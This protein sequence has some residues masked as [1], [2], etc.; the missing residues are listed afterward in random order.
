MSPRRRRTVAEGFGQRR[1]GSRWQIEHLG[2]RRCAVVRDDGHRNERQ[3][4]VPRR[5]EVYWRHDQPR[6]HQQ[7][8]HRGP[9]GVARSDPDRVGRPPGPPLPYH[10]RASVGRY[11]GTRVALRELSTTP[12]PSR[13]MRRS[14]VRVGGRQKRLNRGGR[15]VTEQLRSAADQPALP[16][17]LRLSGPLD[18]LYGAG[19]LIRIM[20]DYRNPSHSQ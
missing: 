5:E 13:C 19:P 6:Q 7:Q 11:T 17:R 10:R 14:E 4:H 16:G 9:H 20:F 2:S 15:H 18:R 8:G 12:R 3:A 1:R